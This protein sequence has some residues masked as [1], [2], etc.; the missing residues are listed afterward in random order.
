M[1]F[2]R[3]PE[4]ACNGTN[5]PGIVHRLDK[6]TAGS[7]RHREDA[8][9]PDDCCS[10]SGAAGS[11]VKCS[12]ALVHGVVAEP[13][14]ATIDVPITADE[15]R[16]IAQR[17]G[18]S[19][20]RSTRG[21]PLHRWRAYFGDHLSRSPNRNRSHS[22]DSRAPCHHRSPRCGRPRSI[23]GGFRPTAGIL[24]IVQAAVPACLQVGFALPPMDSLSNS[25]H[26]WRRTS[27]RN[28]L[29]LSCEAPGMRLEGQIDSV[30]TSRDSG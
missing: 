10:N 25:N 11:V 14:E 8:C 2:S 16:L 21:N 27:S 1:L 5:R 4:V 9:W 7:D 20:R 29:E 24:D 17:N 3:Y 28:C 12:I 15:I 19:L 26:L 30:V 18:G 22:P 23:P 13:N 6:D